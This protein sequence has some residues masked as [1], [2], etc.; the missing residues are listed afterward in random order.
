MDS[1]TGEPERNT[2]RCA[3]AR[4][5]CSELHTNFEVVGAKCRSRYKR[6][7]RVR[8][9]QGCACTRL[10]TR[11]KEVG[12]V[13]NLYGTPGW[14]YDSGLGMGTPSLLD[15]TRWLT[16][17]N[18]LEAVRPSCS[19]LV[20]WHVHDREARFVH[21]TPVHNRSQERTEPRL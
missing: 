6:K 11:R 9:R 5:I 8:V 7:H 16:T 17:E 21:S 1:A 19:R 20:D 15:R 12:L 18:G 10:S 4:T 14:N 13:W 3:Y 2:V